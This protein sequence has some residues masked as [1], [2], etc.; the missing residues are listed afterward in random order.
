MLLVLRLNGITTASYCTSPKPLSIST[1][2]RRS[3]A[4]A[5]FR[6]VLAP[7]SLFPARMLEKGILTALRS[8]IPMVPN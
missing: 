6:G 3:W 4:A 1:F 8:L 2:P 5:A 7:R